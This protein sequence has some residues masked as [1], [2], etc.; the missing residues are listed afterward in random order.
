MAQAAGGSQGLFY[1]K[2]REDPEAHILNF[3]FDLAM[4]K[5]PRRESGETRDENGMYRSDKA[6]I[7]AFSN[8]L[9]DSALTWFLQLKWGRDDGQ[10]YDLAGLLT[11]FGA[12]F[13]YDKSDKWRK[14]LRLLTMK[15]GIGQSAENFISQVENEGREIQASDENVR[16]AI[17]NGLKPEVYAYMTHHDL[18]ETGLDQI[19]KWALLAETV[20]KTTANP[21]LTTIYK[22]MEE[23]MSK[24]EGTQMRTVEITGPVVSKAVHFEQAIS[25]DRSPSL[26]DQG[27][28]TSLV[29]QGSTT[30]PVNQG[31]TT[32]QVFHQP[33]EDGSLSEV[34]Q[35]NSGDNEEQCQSLQ[36]RL[37]T[38]S[39]FNFN[40][41]IEVAQVKDEGKGFFRGKHMEDPELHITNFQFSLAS[42]RLPKKTSDEE[43]DENGLYRSD[44][45]E[46]AAFSQTLKDSAQT[47]F[48]KLKWGRED[49]QLYDLQ[50]LLAAFR[51]RFAYDKTNAWRESVKLLQI[52][53]GPDESVENFINHIENEGRLIRASDEIVRMAI[54]NG[55]KPEIYAY[56]THHDPGVMGL[57]L[58]RKWAIVAENTIVNTSVSPQ[59]TALTNKMEECMAKFETTQMRTVGTP[60][61]ITPKGIRCEH[62]STQDLSSSPVDQNQ[63]RKDNQDMNIL[64]SVTQGGHEQGHR[65]GRS[66]SQNRSGKE[67]Q[68]NGQYDER[69]DDYQR[70]YQ[71]DQVD[72][73]WKEQ[74][75]YDGSNGY[76]G[77]GPMQPYTMVQNMSQCVPWGQAPMGQVVQQSIPQP[78]PRDMGSMVQTN[79]QGMGW[80]APTNPMYVGSRVPGNPQYAGSGVS[81]YMQNSGSVGVINQQGGGQMVQQPGSQAMSVPMVYP[82]TNLQAPQMLSIGLSN[83][84]EGTRLQPRER[85]HQGGV[86]RPGQR[87]TGEY[88]VRGVQGMHGGTTGGFQRRNGVVGTNRGMSGHCGG[89]TYDGG[90]CSRCGLQWCNSSICPAR[91]R[92]CN[93]CRRVGHYG[94]KCGMNLQRPREGPGYALNTNILAKGVQRS[95]MT[96]HTLCDTQNT[97]GGGKN[98]VD[99]SYVHVGIDG[100]RGP[101]KLLLDTG[102]RKTCMDMGFAERNGF[103]FDKLRAGDDTSFLSAGGHR[104]KV[105]RMVVARVSLG[106][107]SM[108]VRFHVIRGLGADMILGRNDQIENG[109]SIM[110]D[111]YVDI[112]RGVDRIPLRKL[113]ELARLECEV[114]IPFVSTV[115]VPPVLHDK[116]GEGVLVSDI[117]NG[118]SSKSFREAGTL[119]KAGESISEEGKG[120]R[121]SFNNR[122][123]GGKIQ[124]RSVCISKET[125]VK[126]RDQSAIKEIPK[127]QV[128]EMESEGGTG[129]VGDS[130]VSGLD[131]VQVGGDH[132]TRT[133]VH[134]G[135]CIQ[136]SEKGPEEQTRFL[137]TVT[138]VSSRKSFQSTGNEEVGSRKLV[139]RSGVTSDIGNTG[140]EGYNKLGGGPRGIRLGSGR[141]MKGM[142]KW[143]K[144]KDLPEEIRKYDTRRQEKWESIEGEVE[145]SNT[146]GLGL[147]VGQEYQAAER[148]L[149]QIITA[150][151]LWC[152]IRWVDEDLEDSWT[153]GTDITHG[154]VSQWWGETVE[155]RRQGQ[156]RTGKNGETGE[157]REEYGDNKAIRLFSGVRNNVYRNV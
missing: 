71:C 128:G 40:R 105:V 97:P 3:Q 94:R 131:S 42:K 118:I 135:Q 64:R 90:G 152:L 98:G 1:G 30:S 62:V 50:G 10:L 76:Q 119:I 11:A 104:L 138:E 15:Q 121:E 154:L 45:A 23:M 70:D 18:G 92:R 27:S 140:L 120:I 9:R 108:N 157:R 60:R 61:S 22:K 132:L 37:N 13:V 51:L 19:R 101:Y 150:N 29:D 89:R 115:E 125:T 112:H 117:I 32:N 124:Q 25:R 7:A 114:P 79:P 83:S 122:F 68:N 63:A 127:G 6:E 84:C 74:P 96:I 111:G 53:Q 123:R 75:S 69:Q 59:I 46:I 33:P 47:W 136:V 36:Q 153:L 134:D 107:V 142:A 137:R 100:R 149:G 143:R 58:I 57:D 49:G 82:E 41:D 12:R 93:R 109:L 8:T 145:Q 52:K 95:N 44:K 155:D 26:V 139:V 144:T 5:L 14:S 126:V 39:L 48:L 86:W 24:F 110:C 72:Q 91:T 146:G 133:S 4:K 43:R 65:Q 66:S 106:R 130:R 34:E 28:T 141:G 21:E 113:G 17:F 103:R 20:V 78:I 67:Y 87:G 85:Q 148:I 116:P 102:A 77:S 99:D 81:G 129:K 151:G 38:D 147:E 54:F 56:L 2:H 31:P 73:G 55:L 80:M 156:E 35:R 88:Q 16:N